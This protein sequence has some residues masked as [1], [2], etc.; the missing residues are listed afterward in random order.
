MIQSLNCSMFCD[1]YYS[2]VGFRSMLWFPS[3]WKL[4]QRQL[5]YA[6]YFVSW[7]TTLW[8]TKASSKYLLS[9]WGRVSY[10][11]VSVFEFNISLELTWFMA[12]YAYYRQVLTSFKRIWVIDKEW[13]QWKNTYWFYMI[14]KDSYTIFNKNLNLNSNV[15][16]HILFLSHNSVKF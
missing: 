15:I 11:N 8:F 1:C 4:I 7:E 16:I 13:P 10:L 6:Q 12:S 2:E 3:C 5:L 14:L 9:Q